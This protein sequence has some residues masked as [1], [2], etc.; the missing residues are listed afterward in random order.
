MAQPTQNKEKFF[1]ENQVPRETRI[2]LERYA[3]LLVEENEKIN[4]VAA[5]TIPDLWKRHFWDSAQLF[6]LLPR[7]TTCLVDLGSGAGFPG[8]VL[9]IMGGLEVHLIESIGKKAR[10]LEK[11]AAELA[12][13]VTVHQERAEKIRNLRADVVTARA[14][15]PLAE[16]LSLAKPFLK[17]DGVC[18]FLKGQKADA[19]L[20]EARKYWTF[21][22]EKRESRTDPS[23]AVLLIRDLRQR[24]RKGN[25][26]RSRA[27]ARSG[28]FAGRNKGLKD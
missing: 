9:A 19:E 26:F 4:L 8:L 3:T 20:T 22:A 21:S 17:S 13:N 28:S 10:F 6:A 11:V 14:V 12:P 23:G 24:V 27:V 2:K 18:L 1:E 25:S 16:L 15:A 7:E 5:S